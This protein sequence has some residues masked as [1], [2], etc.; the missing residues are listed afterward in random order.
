MAR[1]AESATSESPN[2]SI[3]SIRTVLPGRRL[4]F[5]GLLIAVVAVTILS[6]AFPVHGALVSRSAQAGAGPAAIAG[7]SVAL[8]SPSAAS[9]LTL[10]ISANPHSIC[11][12]HLDT[13]AAGTGT[14]RVTLT[15]NAG[16]AGVIAWPAVQVAFVIE[17][18][19]Y[20]GVYDP[21]AG[22][23]GTDPCA[24]SGGGQGLLCE[25]SNGVP[26]FIANAQTIA[27]AIQQAN[28]HSQVTFAMVDYFATK[29]DWDDGDG[30]EY[31]VD[32]PQFIP[33]ATF[34][35][36]VQGSFQATVLNGGWSYSDSDMSDNNFHSS[37][38][39]A[40]YGTIIGSGLDWSNNTHH[41][42]VWMGSTVPRDPNY[43]VNLCVSSEDQY[44]AN[45]GCVSSGCEPSYTFQSGSSP[46]CEGWVKSQDGNRT[47]SIAALAHTVPECTLSIG[48]VCTIDTIDVWTTPTDPL[49]N[50]WPAGGNGH[51]GGGPGGSVVQ[52]NVAKVLLAG[53][54]L[55][56]ATGG[57]WDG[58]AW[59]TCPNGQAGSLQY[60][61]HGKLQ[62][63]N[64]YN[65]TLFQAF[66]QV[67]FGPVLETQVASGSGRPIFEYVPFGT[68][69]MAP[70]LQATAACV[71]NGV[72]LPTCQTQPSVLHFD[73]V[74][75]LGWNWSRNA[76]SNVMYIGDYWTASF[77]VIATGPPYAL[78]PVD[79]CITTDCKAGGSGSL[80]GIY[81]WATYVP[82]TNISVVTQSFPLGQVNVLV[83]P[84]A[85]P[86]PSIPPPPPPVPPP[87][88]I[89]APTP[90]P[91]P[92]QI[93]I[94]QNVG[95]ANLSLQ[96]TAAGFLGAG[97]MR[98]G[99]KNR[100]IAMKIAAKSGPQSSKFD[101][102]ASRKDTGIG[103]FE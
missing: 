10:G 21:F 47:H 12:F 98:V 52:A 72:T 70:D 41:V 14:S 35:S 97:F 37:S 43:A 78:V 101:A 40:L 65:P 87:F 102:E 55:A 90:L 88:P 26:F 48:G 6:T 54:D 93:G 58:P 68:I 17:T 42:I 30:A 71:R 61:P 57:T 29:T 81:T 27:N 77:N 24:N 92:Q 3:S 8:A 28:P 5:L 33:A 67:G 9:A 74:T 99:L 19:S 38:I 66:R 79:A 86:P 39:T 84:P 20:D 2:P 18:T 7:P 62:Q 75:Y 49:S 46:N 69:T 13:C 25:E 100:P 31:H 32:I 51:A 82:Y 16:S 45:Q 80:V 94:G 15:A 4:A 64:T 85:A 59:F 91:V 76:S 50:G 36:A 103:R 96:A 73:G 44:Y 63:P 22:E 1:A 83:T 60:V 89:A 95:L 56:A 34:G 11:A 23:P 53:C